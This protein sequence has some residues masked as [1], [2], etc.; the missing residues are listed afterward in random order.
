MTSG[1]QTPAIEPDEYIALAPESI[2]TARDKLR[3][4]GDRSN[5]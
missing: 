2:E 4:C 5:R 1:S 3:R